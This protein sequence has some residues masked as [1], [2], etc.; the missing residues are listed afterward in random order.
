MFAHVS[1]A[2][3][4]ST[5][6][7]N[8]LLAYRIVLESQHPAERN[9]GGQNEVGNRAQGHQV[10][11]VLRQNST[12]LLAVS[13]PPPLTIVILGS[14]WKEMLRTPARKLR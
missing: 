5:A 11:C 13:V 12:L 9:G 4:L 14:T 10:I 2:L 1:D 8:H 6:D 7:S 3:A